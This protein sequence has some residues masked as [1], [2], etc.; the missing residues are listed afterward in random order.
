M[1]LVRHS[2]NFKLSR[3][4]CDQ[5][6]IGGA[7]EYRVSPKLRPVVIVADQN[8]DVNYVDTATGNTALH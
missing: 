5:T 8:L 1:A 2:V 6:P 4:A 3:W 7:S